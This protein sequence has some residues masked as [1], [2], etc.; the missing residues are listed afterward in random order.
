M[1]APS[2]R[3]VCH[4]CGTPNEPGAENCA[5]CRCPAV[6]RGY[7]LSPPA[8]PEAEAARIREA[9]ASRNETLSLFLPEALIAA[10]I[11]LAAP[12][13]ALS[14]MFEGHAL[15]GGLLVAGVS[16]GIYGFYWFMKRREKWL[17]YFSVLVVLFV[18]YGVYSSTSS[19]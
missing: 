9:T 8:L 2:Y 13:W 4:K 10:V 19:G 5:S 14:L 12:S 17:A 11:A 16:A 15:T 7:E 18:A 6:L 3:W 1:S